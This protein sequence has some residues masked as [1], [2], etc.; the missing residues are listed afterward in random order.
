MAL[1]QILEYPDERLRT[2]A[3]PVAK[4]NDEIRKLIDSMLET[5][6][7]SKGVGLAATQVDIHKRIVVMDFSEEGNDPLVLINP[8]FEPIG[9]DL[10]DLSEGCL[11]V[12]GFFELLDRFAEVR[13]TALDRD[14]EEFS[15]ELDGL[16][17]VCVQHELDHLNGKLFVDYLSKLKQDRIRKKLIKNKRLETA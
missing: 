9:E 11:S 13:L 6:Y 8:E 16:A 12:P 2:I 3:E 1:L 4:V 7:E 15:M 14:G 17:A 10:T 5:M